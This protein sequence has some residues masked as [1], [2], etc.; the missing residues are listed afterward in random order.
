MFERWMSCAD[1]IPAAINALISPNRSNIL[2]SCPPSSLETDVT[3]ISSPS[4]IVRSVN[5]W[6]QEIDL[7]ANRYRNDP[8]VSPQ[9][10]GNRWNSAGLER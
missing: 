10:E 2:T 4:R 3:T 8:S 7:S 9:E 5:N 6:E 1:S